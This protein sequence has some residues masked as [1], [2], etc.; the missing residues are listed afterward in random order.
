[1]SEIQNSYFTTNVRM[2]MNQEIYKRQN[3]VGIQ[4]PLQRTLKDEFVSQHKKNG[5]IERL[6]NYVKNITGLGIG[7]KKVE[8]EIAKA[9]NGEISE[10]KARETITRYKNSQTNSAQGFGDLLSIGASGI[11]FFGMGNFLKMKNS[12]LLL[13]EKLIDNLTNGLKDASKEAKK[14]FWGNLTETVIKTAKSKN[15]LIALT[16]ISAGFVGGFT[17]YWALKFNRIGSEEF[18]TNKKDFNGAKTP[19]D[20]S[21]YKLEK[22]AKAK[23]RRNANFRN[24]A[25]GAI[26]GLMMPLTTLGG[27]IVGVPSYFVANSFNR[28]FVG[29]KDSVKTFDGYV[30]NLK[31]DSITHATVAVAAAIPMVKKVN[32]TKVYDANLKKATDKLLA[33]DLRP[34]EFAGKTTYRELEDILMN[35]KEIKEI[36]DSAVSD[37]EKIK[38]M[39]EKNIFSVKF[40]QIS[41]GEDSLS[42]AL[43]ENCPTTRTLEQAQEYISKQLGNSYNVSKCLG[44]GTIAETYLAKGADGKEV[45]IKILKEGISAD[46]IK[47]DRDSFVEIIKGL[48]RP[49]QEEEY[50]I[51]NI[52]DL[53]EGISKEVD[54][55]NEMNAANKLV[56]FTKTAK[57][58]KPIEVKNGVY[59]M[60]KANGIS[61]Q[62]LIKLNKL[63]SEEHYCTKILEDL[64]NGKL[65]KWDEDFI[66][67]TKQ[68]R[69]EYI[70]NE[71]SQYERFLKSAQEQI[72]IIEARTPE[73]GDI[74]LSDTDAKYLF[75]EYM[76]VMVEQFYK[77]DKAGKTI[78]ADIHPGNV[79][80]DINAL[81][82]RKGQIF[83]LIDTG[84]TIDLTAKQAADSLKLATYLKR[85]DV[86]DI[87]E[88]MMDGA[89]LEGSSLTKEEAI[90]KVSDELKQCFFDDKTALNSMNTT[91]LFNMVSNIMKKYNIMPSSNQL[92]L[93]KARTSAD[94]S[95]ANLVGIWFREADKKLSEKTSTVGKAA[96]GVTMIKDALMLQKKYKKMQSTQEKLNLLQMSPTERI[97][98]ERNP[99][100]L[101]TNSED[102]LTYKLKQSIVENG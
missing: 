26:N 61:L 21:A 72:K 1:M 35:S 7:S 90:K 91:E 89:I 9:E 29:N 55:S 42:V 27:A 84:N 52:D 4:A 80:I 67:R 48:K 45:C 101:P 19:Y 95:Y 93:E 14:S 17:K 38:A 12:E 76:K 20:K 57:V 36:L 46:K 85:A 37:A 87:V 23:E 60:E 34:S 86:P 75:E 33:A 3:Y 41:G 31:D 102:Y 71:I 97:K 50:L 56:N 53:A 47:K 79:F 82:A 73:F 8:A 2:P 99:N 32:W 88:Y 94:R 54:F 43:T 77:I 59:V 78:H 10:E 51:R 11:T 100:L 68:S 30:N 98:Y 66:I 15:K 70:A 44:V 74:K 18:K 39:S 83:T 22:K 16:A 58:V 6:Y 25:S 5:L 24:F 92:N 13:N 40:K 62:S 64:K 96:S 69:E 81:R 63:Q 49:K 65:S 28:Y